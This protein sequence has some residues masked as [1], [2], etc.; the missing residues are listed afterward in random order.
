MYID[1]ERMT[2]GKRTDRRTEKWIL[3]ETERQT[4]KSIEEDVYNKCK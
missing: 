2:S 1:K 4:E 3:K